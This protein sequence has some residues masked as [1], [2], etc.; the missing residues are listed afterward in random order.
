[1]QHGDITGIKIVKC[2]KDKLGVHSSRQ[3]A[4]EQVNYWTLHAKVKL[5]PKFLVLGMSTKF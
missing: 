4:D 2:P 5:H 3:T 1:M